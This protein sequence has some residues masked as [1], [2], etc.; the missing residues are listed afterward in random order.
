MKNTELRK[1]L[2]SPS[3]DISCFS[4]REYTTGVGTLYY[5]DYK[6]DDEDITFVYYKRID[7]ENDFNLI[8]GTQGK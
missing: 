4:K 2:D 3:V 1:L 8:D 5:I 6:K 7:R